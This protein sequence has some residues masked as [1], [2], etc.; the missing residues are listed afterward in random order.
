MCLCDASS[1]IGF[2]LVVKKLFRFCLFEMCCDNV[3]WEGFVELLMRLTFSAGESLVDSKGSLPA[4]QTTEIT[5]WE[6]LGNADMLDIELSLFSW[7]MLSS[8]HH[9]EHSSSTEH[10]EDEL[11]KAL[12]VFGLI[13]LTIY[14]DIY[15]VCMH[16]S[17]GID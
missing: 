15:T 8:L 10:S 3:M 16:F 9:T 13:Y 4:G 17:L 11:N 5:L 1:S 2:S 12:E 6:R 7:D 14:R